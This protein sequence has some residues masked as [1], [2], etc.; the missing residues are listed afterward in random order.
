MPTLHSYARYSPFAFYH[1]RSGCIINVNA[2]YSDRI[3]VG[4]VDI[5]EIVMKAII[6]AMVM[7]YVGTIDC[8]YEGF[9]FNQLYI[10]LSLVSYHTMGSDTQTNKQTNRRT[11]KQK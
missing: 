2:L 3:I 5:T 11:N 1:R 8:F 4:P 6:K 10:G 9:S 7:E